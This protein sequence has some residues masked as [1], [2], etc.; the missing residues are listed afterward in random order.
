M[1]QKILS[2]YKKVVNFRFPPNL[3]QIPPTL[4]DKPEQ[5]RWRTKQNLDYAFAMLHVYFE[6]PMTRYYVQLEDDV[7]TVPRKFSSIWD[8]D[9]LQ[10]MQ[11]LSV[12]CDDFQTLTQTF[13]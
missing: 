12:N 7:V 1:V 2:L 9:Y 10:I 4:G 13:T 5:M 8:P 3:E 11:T 6:R